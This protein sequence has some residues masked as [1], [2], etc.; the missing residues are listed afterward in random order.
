MNQQEIKALERVIEYLSEEKAD[1]ESSGNRKNHIYNDI[2]ILENWLRTNPACS[3]LAY[4]VQKN[5]KV[6]C[7]SPTANP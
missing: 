7:K 2:A 5:K 1:Y 6:R 4:A 3:G